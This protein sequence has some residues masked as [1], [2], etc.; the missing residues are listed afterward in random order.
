MG[1]KEPRDRASVTIADYYS[2]TGWDGL[3][4][5]DIV[6]EDLSMNATPG[7]DLLELREVG[8]DAWSKFRLPADAT[9]CA[10]TVHSKH[11]LTDTRYLVAIVEVCE[12]AESKYD[13]RFVSKMLKQ[14]WTWTRIKR[15]SSPTNLT[16]AIHMLSIIVILAY[17]VVIIRA[18][19]RGAMRKPLKILLG[20]GLYLVSMVVW[21]VVIVGLVSVMETSDSGTLGFLGIA[22]GLALTRPRFTALM[23]GSTG[24]WARRP[25]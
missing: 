19:R 4:A 24:S 8:S 2:P 5:I 12:G 21:R 10:L 15:T 20:V 1:I 17:A 6:R 18:A 22:S 9:G 14:L 25:R 3:N 11:V 13:Q 7:F 23:L 16:G